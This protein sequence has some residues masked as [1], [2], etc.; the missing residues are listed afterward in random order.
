MDSN[1]LG[2]AAMVVVILSAFLCCVLVAK[3]CPG[4]VA[5]IDVDD[6][7]DEPG[8]AIGLARV[9]PVAEGGEAA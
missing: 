3:C 7:D 1:M 9:N 8:P 5:S 4:C 6:D 2:I